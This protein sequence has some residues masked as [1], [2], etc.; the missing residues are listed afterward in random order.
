VIISPEMMLSK[1]FIENVLKKPEIGPRI[2]SVIVDEA[3]VVS[4][5]GSEFRK[6]YG[7]L[8]KLRAL[9][10]KG[11]SFVA[12]SAT[13]PPRVHKD[14][15]NK[16]LF[17]EKNH[18]YLN[19]GNDRP[20]VSIVVRPIHNNMNTYIDL[21]FLIPSNV[22][23]PCQIKKGFI[24]ADSV[25]DGIGIENRLYTCLPETLRGTGIIQPY[26]A[27]YTAAHREQLMKLFKEG[28]IHILIC[29]D[30]AGMVSY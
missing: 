9:L 19:I 15:L 14:V 4:H 29:T 2:L 12:M 21:D 6:Q 11:T 7:T 25:S 26:N 3:H 5:W 10:P 28:V 23:Q 18:T 30:A 1:S 20:N 16:L 22:A 24:Y 27:A 17:D 8:G 13:L